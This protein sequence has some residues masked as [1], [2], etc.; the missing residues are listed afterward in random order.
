MDNITYFHLI[1]TPHLAGTDNSSAE[2]ERNERKKMCN[3]YFFSI[4]K[5]IANEKHKGGEN[6]WKKTAVNYI[7]EKNQ[8]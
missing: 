5:R 8:L 1:L 3:K 6:E 7:N 4:P 2:R